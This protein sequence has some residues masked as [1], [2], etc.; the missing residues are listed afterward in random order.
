MG[1]GRVGER[2][3]DKNY[4]SWREKYRLYAEVEVYT[5]FLYYG[6]RSRLLHVTRAYDS[7]AYYNL[8]LMWGAGHE[9][10]STITLIGYSL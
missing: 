7:E 6:H 4:F 10:A 2:R 1:G 5:R 8:Y 9:D 3:G